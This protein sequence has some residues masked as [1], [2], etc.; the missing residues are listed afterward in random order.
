MTGARKTHVITMVAIVAAI[1]IGLRHR[2]T[3]RRDPPS[4]Q[5]AVYAMLDAS[6]NGNVA[7]YLA[8][9][10]GPMQQS[11][12]ASGGKDSELSKYLRDSSAALKGVAVGEP[13]AVSDRE[14]SVRVEY[15]YQD[16]NETQT[17]L[18]EKAGDGWKIERV[19]GAER[20]KTLVPYG[21][22]VR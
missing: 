10:T 11:L 8:A 7:A 16:R 5:D 22:P 21:T 18:L 20:I 17:M 9:Y 12:R 19:D 2:Q 4:P 15:V 6:R 1:G 13:Q 3:A 14:S